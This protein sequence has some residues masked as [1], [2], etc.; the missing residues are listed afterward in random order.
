MS[1]HSR[2]LSTEI[3]VPTSWPELFSAWL[4]VS[5]GKALRHQVFAIAGWLLLQAL[6]TRHCFLPQFF[7]HLF[8]HDSGFESILGFNEDLY[9]GAFMRFAFNLAWQ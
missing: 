9:F 5:N 8:T 1:R 3:L 2:I 7:L 6:S 4:A